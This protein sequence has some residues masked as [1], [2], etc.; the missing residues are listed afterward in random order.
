[1]RFGGHEMAAGLSLKWEDFEAFKKAVHTYAEPLIDE[2]MLVPGMDIDLETDIKNIDL[3]FCEGMER[4]EPFGAYNPMPV[5]SITANVQYAQRIG[6]DLNHLKLI[7]EKDNAVM[8]A[9]GFY[10]GYLAEYLT[11]GETIIIGGE[12]TKNVW[13]NKTSIQLRIKD[14]KSTE[15]VILK[16]KYYTSLYT[17]LKNPQEIQVKHIPVKK[18]LTDAAT[19]KI[20]NVYTEAAL[21]KFYEQMKNNTENINLNLKICYNKVCAKNNNPIVCINP[22]KKH[23]SSQDY[24]WDYQTISETFEAPNTLLDNHK[25]QLTK[26]IPSHKDCVEVYKLLKNNVLDDL[27]IHKM[28]MALTMYDMTEYKLF[29]ILEIFKELNILQW[30]IAEDKIKYNLIASGKTK[31]EASDRYAAL[32]KFSKVLLQI[33]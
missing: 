2:E 32:Q 23:T 21:N 25:A 31:L 20:I 15:D 11:A 6:K 14:I 28:V 16:N 27:S 1:L 7:V 4:L 24:E 26:M 18:P 8:Q 9:I 5:L 19:S 22:I 13:N 17:Y 10:K 12:I 33:N 29:Q 3:D 30:Y